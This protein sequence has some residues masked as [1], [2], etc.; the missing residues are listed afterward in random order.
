MKK[1]TAVLLCAAAV[2]FTASFLL[3]GPKQQ[4]KTL[5]VS[6]KKSTSYYSTSNTVSSQEN[7]ITAPT[8][9]G[10][11]DTYIVKE[12]EGHI[13][14]YRNNETKPFKEYDTDVLILPKSDQVKLKQG[15][16]AHT[17]AEVEKMVEDFDG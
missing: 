4:T 6:S 17:M 10:K 9:A 12:Y 8:Q 2:I 3:N 15:K 1:A 13:G 16:T 7:G 5:S 14:V 11:S